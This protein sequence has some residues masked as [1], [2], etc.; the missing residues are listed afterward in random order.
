M[1]DSLLFCMESSLD[2]TNEQHMEKGPD[3]QKENQAEQKD[4][5]EDD[6]EE[7][8]ESEDI[9]SGNCLEIPNLT[10]LWVT[11]HAKILYKSSCMAVAAMHDSQYGTN[12]VLVVTST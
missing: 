4:E 8:D 5:T 7:D 6:E 2:E 12:S 9:I 1:S 3:Q 10:F 11:K